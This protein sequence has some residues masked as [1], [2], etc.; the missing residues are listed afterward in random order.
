MV[1]ERKKYY[2]LTWSTGYDNTTP[3]AYAPEDVPLSHEL[4]PKVTGLAELPF[5]LELESVSIGNK[6]LRRLGHLDTNCLPVDYQPNSLAWPLMSKKMKE[7]I[8]NL[9]IRNEGLKWIKA[10]V[11][12]GGTVY[13]YFIPFFSKKLETLDYGNTSFVPNTDHIINPAFD[14]NKTAQYE[15]FH[16]HSLFWQI[17]PEIYISESIKEELLND[18]V[19]GVKFERIKMF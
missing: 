8:D 19:S 7:I 5:S 1:I 11:K 12:G 14:Y 10:N 9:L 18:L 3:V 15:I 13:S 2:W 17:T 6:G 4:T 16:G